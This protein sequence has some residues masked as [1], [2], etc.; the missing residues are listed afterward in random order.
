[1]IIDTC[2]LNWIRQLEGVLC[3][4]LDESIEDV[5][6]IVADVDVNLLAC[7]FIRLVSRIINCTQFLRK[8]KEYSYTTRR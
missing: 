7:C 5:V 1:M 3:S 8:F 2:D 6:S 4:Q